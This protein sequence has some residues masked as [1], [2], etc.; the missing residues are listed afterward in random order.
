LT[1]YLYAESMTQD[2]TPLLE[3][4]QANHR[5]IAAY[6]A[7]ANLIE[8]A[9]K[10]AGEVRTSALME[11]STER[12]RNFNRKQ[13]LDETLRLVVEEDMPLIQAKMVATENVAGN[14]STTAIVG[15]INI[16]GSILSQSILASK[17]NPTDMLSNY[18]AT[19]T[20]KTPDRWSRILLTCYRW[21]G[22]K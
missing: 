10:T 14:N 5:A 12:E 1:G 22:G 8:E 3:Q 7:K 4:M 2:I 19:K 13:I 20:E 17:V 9:Y 11:L 15:N 6:R 21:F 16:T 18:F